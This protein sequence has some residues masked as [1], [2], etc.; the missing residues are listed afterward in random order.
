MRIPARQR[1][2]DRASDA[3]ADASH[4][5]AL[6]TVRAL[7]KLISNLNRGMAAKWDADGAL[8]VHSANTRGATYRTTEHACSCPAF[9]DYCCHRRLRDIILDIQATDAQTADHLA[10][11]EYH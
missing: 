8:L 5:H 6:D 3:R 10:A 2:I 9:V 4:H 7:D 1:I 11:V